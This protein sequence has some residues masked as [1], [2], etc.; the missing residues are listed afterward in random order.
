M[1]QNNAANVAKIIRKVKIRIILNSLILK[2]SYLN[3]IAKHSFMLSFA[4]PMQL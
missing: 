3:D 1:F 4:L 2:A